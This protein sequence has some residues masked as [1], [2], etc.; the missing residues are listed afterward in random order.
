MFLIIFH[1]A[2][3]S[4]MFLCVG[5]VEHRLGSRD[6]EDMDN[7]IVRMPK[8]AIMMIIG[9]GGMFVAPFGML[10]SK[11]AAIRAFIDINRAL[12]PIILVILAFGSAVTV[13]FWSKWIGKMIAAYNH[14]THR[15]PLE[16]E[17]S[18]DESFSQITHAILTVG[19]CI[20][21]PLIS[22]TLVEPYILSIYGHTFDINRSNFIITGI[23]VALVILLP[24]ISIPR[25]KSHFKYADPYISGRNEYEG[26]IYDASMDT[27]IQ[28]TLKNFYLEKAFGEARL[29]KT[30]LIIS[31]IL[32]IL[33]LGAGLL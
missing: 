1:A 21:F 10:I 28:L 20:L 24:V 18:T 2:A 3:K 16:D 11:W 27:R 7:I 25:H 31:S 33:M 32:V 6:L 12:S 14:R 17:V 9:I 13:L 23:M 22:Y 8:L 19:I 4:L 29:M 26:R 30:G 5:T 15:D